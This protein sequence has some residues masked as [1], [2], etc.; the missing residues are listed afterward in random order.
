MQQQTQ[1]NKSPR[2][3]SKQIQAVATP[4]SKKA[5]EYAGPTFH[6]SPAPA[7]LPPPPFLA[8]SI[9]QQKDSLANSTSGSAPSSLPVE[10][11]PL[12]FLFS[13]MQK[14]ESL[15]RYQSESPPVLGFQSNLSATN[16]VKT[17]HNIPAR[18]GLFNMDGEDAALPAT[19]K[20]SRRTAAVSQPATA[21]TT[22]PRKSPWAPTEKPRA[23]SIPEQESSHKQEEVSA[24]TAGFPTSATKRTVGDKS[25]LFDAQDG[26]GS[27][28]NRHNP[29]SVKG[30]RSS[31]ETPRKKK[32]HRNTSAT[33]QATTPQSVSKVTPKKIL[34]R[35]VVD[36]QPGPCPSEPKSVTPRETASSTFVPL[37]KTR[38]PTPQ[39]TA[40][41]EVE[42]ED[43]LRQQAA[44]LMSILHLPT[45][46]PRD[47]SPARSYTTTSNAQTSDPSM[48]ESDLRRLL[49]LGA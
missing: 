1:Q 43:D 45:P 47:N 25:R 2:A 18:S 23:V 22:A 38:A 21:N 41:R 5:A 6:H 49:K 32:A 13:A 16:V 36:P 15:Q 27:S 8:R 11:S 29:N 9:S 44:H 35:E 26:V 30:G 40:K 42:S 33:S 46:S 7:N 3:R 24:K 12:S 4:I 14:E 34:K 28:T 37:K 20:D 39:K 31:T 48:I 19:R 10:S 17:D